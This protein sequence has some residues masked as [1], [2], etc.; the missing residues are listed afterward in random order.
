MGMG[1]A[2][3]VEISYIRLFFEIKVKSLILTYIFYVSSLMIIQKLF[4]QRNTDLEWRN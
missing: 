3:G 1:A 2:G 4:R